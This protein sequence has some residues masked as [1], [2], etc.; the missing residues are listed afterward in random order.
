MMSIFSARSIL[1]FL[2]LGLAFWLSAIDAVAAQAAAAPADGAP[3]PEM[4]L[5]A[6]EV[7]GEIEAGEGRLIELRTQLD[8]EETPPLEAIGLELGSLRQSL[9]SA[10]DRLEAEIAVL[11]EALSR[12]DPSADPGAADETSSGDPAVESPQGAPGDASQQADASGGP[13]ITAPV[14]AAA[15]P[16]SEEARKEVADQLAALEPVAAA[17][18]RA[19]SDLERL[20][21]EVAERRRLDEAR[22]GVDARRAELEGV[23]LALADD[24]PEPDYVDLRE[25]LRDLRARGEAAIAPLRERRDELRADLDRLGAAPAEGEPAE[26][27]EIAAERTALTASLVKEDA[28]VRQSDLNLAEISRLLEDIDDR[29][30][31]QFYSQI[32]R[33]GE[34]PLQWETIAGAAE[35]FLVGVDR[36]RANV[37]DWRERKERSGGLWRAY[38][39]ISLS[40][41]VS[42]F[43]FGPIRRWANRSI[44]VRL[45]ANEPTPGARAGVAIVRILA[46]AVPGIIA[47][48]LVYEALLVQGLIPDYATAFA[49][50]IWFGFLG[51]LTADAGVVAVFA[52]K[53]PG[54]RLVP[55][56]TRGVGIVRAATLTL[57]LLFFADRSL[58]EGAKIYG[59]NEELALI[60]SAVVAISMALVFLVL[61]QKSVW[62]LAEGRGDAFGED[63]RALWNLSRR[64]LRIIAIAII[65]AAAVG[66]VALAHYLATR[67]FMLDGIIAAGMFIRIMSHQALRSADAALNGRPVAAEGEP[68]QERLVLFW[69]GAVLDLVII[70]AL[71]PV[72][73]LA[74]GAEWEDVRNWIGDAFFGFQLGGVTISIAQILAAVGV[75]FAILTLTKFI[76]R[77]GEKR[78]FPHTRLDVGV[79]N[80]LKTLIGYLGLLIGVMVGASVLG[81]NLSNLAIIAGAL[82]VGIG[83]GLQ[84]IVNNFVSGLILLFE[85]PIKVGDWI[86]TPSGEGIVKRISVRATEIETFDRASVIVPNSEL[87]SSAVTNWTHKNKMGRV[88]I[89]VGVSYDSDPEQVIHLLEEVARD[90]HLMLAYPPPYVYF[91]GF[92]DSSLDFELR[93]LIRDVN[94]SLSTK[95]ALRVAVFK[96]LTEAGVEIPFPQRDL[97]IRTE[98]QPPAPAHDPQPEQEPAPAQTGPVLGPAAPPEGMD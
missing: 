48:G 85:R 36:M 45:Q 6:D 52:P 76:Q 89:A 24:G 59:G 1:Q 84:S 17:A 55:L 92:G 78:F 28:I 96:K 38:A 62:K 94:S 86:V 69:V 29:R 8:E 9:E 60:Q 74:L 56:V 7:R 51:L 21:A 75:F 46:R 72:V 61:A 44:I 33:R 16:L 35:T 95:T 19:L 20:A 26:A 32:L 40:L 88:I 12:T 93:G 64:L 39:I 50:S 10:R 90:T 2:L 82:S 91:V 43:L 66:Y 54:W 81:F 80:S 18:R 67:I 97:H 63:V 31:E 37:A 71:T 77:L 53:T 70:L 68:A 47:G 27:E 15:P 98:A 58:S 41:V 57:V 14:E 79:Q 73:F 11:R 49:R 87:I 23:R 30:R 5:D 13:A 25:T 4:T 83:F 65:A 3:P 42:L 34:S 22:S